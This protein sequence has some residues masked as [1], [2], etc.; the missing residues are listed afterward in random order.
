MNK[1]R[2]LSTIS[3]ILELL[4]CTLDHH[5]RCLSGVLLFILLTSRSRQRTLVLHAAQ[6]ARGGRRA[7]L[8]RR[9]ASGDPAPVPAPER[10][11]PPSGAPGS[12]RARG[13]AAAWGRAG[14]HLPARP[15]AHGARDAR[16]A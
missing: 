15:R 7:S 10:G 12:A 1:I 2:Y 8:P 5:I 11:A 14:E 3:E 9:A 4:M 13:G 6:C 16:G